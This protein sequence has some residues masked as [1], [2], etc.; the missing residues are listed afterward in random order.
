MKK[1]IAVSSLAGACIGLFQMLGMLLIDMENG[2][3]YA[4]KRGSLLRDGF[5]GLLWAVVAFFLCFLIWKAGTRFFTA[6]KKCPG[7]AWTN[8]LIYQGIIF[9]GWLPCYLA[10]FP[11]IYSY[12]GE[13]QLIQYTTH[14]FDSHHPLLHTLFLG[15]CYDMGQF[16]HTKLH[17][18][19]DGMAIYSLIQMLILAGAFACGIRFLA[20]LHLNRL[21]LV[22]VTAWCILFP[23]NPLMAVTTTKDTLFTAFL[24]YTLIMLAEVLT[25]G[26]LMGAP[27]TFGLFFSA[28]CMMLIRKN[29]IYIMLGICVVLLPVWIYKTVKKNV[30]GRFYQKLF[31]LTA[32]SV[33]LFVL[34][35]AGLLKLTGGVKGEAAEALSIPIQELARA[36]KSNSS[37]MTEKMREDLYVYLP[38]E[39]L[40][41]YR[42]YISDGVKQY[43][44]NEKYREDPSDFFS[45]WFRVLK[46]YPGSCMTAVLYHT[47]GS[48]YPCDV[49][50]S[51]LYQ[52][53]WRDRTGYLITDAVPVFAGDF[54]KKENLLPAVRTSYEKLATDCIHQRF[55]PTMLLFSPAI[56]CLSLVFGCLILFLRKRWNFL[57]PC[58]ALLVYLMTVIAGPCILVRYVYPFMAVMPFLLAFL[59]VPCQKK[60]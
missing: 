53:W 40:E 58:M 22:S 3:W 44:N 16:F 29:G 38:E 26:R 7:K 43:F 23:V 60:C 55:L 8:P 28:L 18:A 9:L 15:W 17:F 31:L 41:N 10:Y 52:N 57:L 36:Y 50:H 14:A 33:M 48:W 35:D 1:K 49:S 25:A 46:Q 54:V 34:C 37:S 5:T 12:D 45:V 56:Y 11:A 32:A 51:T 20:S 19:M 39:G 24:L 4:D 2:R 47:M 21:V 59:W 6:A 30:N 42:P 13:P 27:H